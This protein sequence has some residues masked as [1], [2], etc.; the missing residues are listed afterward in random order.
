MH[1]AVSFFV[2][3][4][5]EFHFFVFEILPTIGIIN[6]LYIRNDIRFISSLRSFHEHDSGRLMSI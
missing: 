3:L 1:T 4:R 2:F 6:L 5:L